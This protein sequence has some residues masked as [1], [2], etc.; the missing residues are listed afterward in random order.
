MKETN[1]LVLD[2][3]EVAAKEN[4]KSWEV[5]TLQTM[6]LIGCGHL[7]ERIALNGF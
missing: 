3:L 4:G 7:S 5:T 2:D 6:V 1:G